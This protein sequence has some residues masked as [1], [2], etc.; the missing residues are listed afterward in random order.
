[1]HSLWLLLPWYAG[2]IAWVWAAVVAVSAAQR[3]VAGYRALR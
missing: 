3:T 2:E 1:M